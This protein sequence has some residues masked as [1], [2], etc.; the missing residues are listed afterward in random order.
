MIMILRSNAWQISRYAC[1]FPVQLSSLLI[2]IYY[3]FDV[4]NISLEYLIKNE[5]YNFQSKKVPFISD[6]IK[7]GTDKI[8]NI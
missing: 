3:L 1:N 2:C 5:E 6:I 4:S 7:I 8:Q